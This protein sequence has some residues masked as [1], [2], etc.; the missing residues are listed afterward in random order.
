MLTDMARTRVRWGRIVGLAA[1]AAV[2]VGAAGGAA[3]AGGGSAEARP[4]RDG[5]RPYVVAP[6]D[7][8]W[9]IAVRIAGRDADPR[10]VVEAIAAANHTS[11]ELTP[12]Q[13]LELPT[14]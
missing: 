1:A 10:P 2:A 11:G 8:L 7:T 9:G 13:V 6:G 3:H 5:V 14:S 12:G 4:R